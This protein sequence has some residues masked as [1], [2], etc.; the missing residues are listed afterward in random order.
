MFERKHRSVFCGKNR[1]VLTLRV[2]GYEDISAIA[3]HT[4]CLEEYIRK[5]ITIAMFYYARCL[6]LGRGVL[7]NRDRAKSYFTQVPLTTLPLECQFWRWTCKMHC[8]RDTRWENFGT[9][10]IEGVGDIR[11][12]SGTQVW[13]LVFHPSGCQDRSRDM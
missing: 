5:G 1:F 7:K 12:S 9:C 8:Y 13:F 4:E 3:Q 11:R 6:Q 10:I 2:S